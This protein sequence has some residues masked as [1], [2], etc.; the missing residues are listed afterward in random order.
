MLSAVRSDT[1]HVIVMVKRDLI[2]VIRNSESLVMTI[3]LPIMV[4]LV[5][6]Y[7]FGGAL[8]PDGD[9]TEYLRYVL[10][11]II[12]MSPAFGAYM[13]GVGVN[14]DMSK[15]I[16]DRFR[17]MDINQSSVWRDILLHLLFAICWEQ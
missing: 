5:F 14:N 3:F 6:V 12:I 4:T 2:H 9:R 13:T 17:T 1:S 15:G 7:V 10:P 11:G 8:G 16:I